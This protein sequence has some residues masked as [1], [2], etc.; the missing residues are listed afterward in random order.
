MDFIRPDDPIR[1]GFL[2]EEHWVYLL[3][4]KTKV[5][6]HRHLVRI[7]RALGPIF[8]HHMH[9][10]EELAVVCKLQDYVIP[11]CPGLA[12]LWSREVRATSPKMSH[13]HA[14]GVSRYEVHFRYGEF[15]RVLYAEGEPKAIFFLNQLLMNRQRTLGEF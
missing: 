13:S 15:S 9:A 1:W 11:G 4:G 3:C 2:N 12:L 8:P 7:H 6:S 10:R 14:D 5:G